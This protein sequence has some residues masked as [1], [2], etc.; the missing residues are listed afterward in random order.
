MKKIFPIL[1][2]FLL[3]FEAGCKKDPLDY[4]T[5]YLGNFRFLIHE[6]FSGPQG[7][8]DT[9]YYADGSIDYGNDKKTIA[10]S[11]GLGYAVDPELFEDASFKGMGMSGDFYSTKKIVFK[12]E[13]FRLVFFYS[14]NATG[15][16][17]K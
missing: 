2:L 17:K 7:D 8:F 11:W 3:F 10:V 14:Y 4:R 9:T 15:E 5:K 12:Y 16:R 13:T 1:L 6:E